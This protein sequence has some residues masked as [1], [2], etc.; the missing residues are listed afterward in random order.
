MG[1]RLNNT[2]WEHLKA[3]LDATLEKA[4]AAAA[5][6][7]TRFDDD[8]AG[9]ASTAA[10]A[11]AGDQPEAPE[12]EPED[13]EELEAMMEN[14]VPGAIQAR[15]SSVM[16]KAKLGRILQDMEKR[17][18]FDD[19]LRLRELEDSRVQD[20]S[21]IEAINPGKGATMAPHEWTTAVRLRLGANLTPTARICG[22][23]GEQT[24]DPQC[25]HALC[26]AQ[27][28]STRGHNLVRDVL[29]ETF[30]LADPTTDKEVAGL[31]PD[32]PD[33]RPADILTQAAHATL[34]T[35]VDVTVRCPYAAGSGDDCAEKGKADKLDHYRSV[36]EQLNHQ[37]IRYAPAVFTSFG[38]RHHDVNVMTNLAARRAARHRG[39]TEAKG[40]VATW[41]RNL[42]VALWTRAARMVHKCLA[43]HRA[44]PDDELGV[45]VCRMPAAT[46]EETEGWDMT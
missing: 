28:E 12:E 23:C 17:D 11:V 35:A 4:K 36:L 44:A 14:R 16:D 22:A 33:L 27:G 9:A 25:Y 21:W 2:G 26:C 8:A 34:T 6:A 30:A 29:A 43:G 42:A 3:Q 15:L 13:K 39:C 5:K 45:G 10:G 40:L 7:W 31:V 46:E 32:K 20:H 38:R 1:N 37:G 19:V 18:M 41:N 24:L